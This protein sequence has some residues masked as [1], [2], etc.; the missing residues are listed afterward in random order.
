[1]YTFD[2]M[3]LLVWVQELSLLHLGWA[4]CGYKSSSAK[5]DSSRPNRSFRM[6]HILFM[7][8]PVQMLGF[9]QLSWAWF[10]YKRLISKFE[11]SKT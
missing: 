7:G 3:L 9:V 2:E 4:L 5:F 8:V 10:G 11:S 1:M 6:K